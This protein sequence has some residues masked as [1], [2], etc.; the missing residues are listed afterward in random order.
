MFGFALAGSLQSQEPTAAD[1]KPTAEEAVKL[2]TFLVTGSNI[3]RVDAETSLPVTVIDREDLDQRGVSTPA[4]LFDTI[5]MAN[6]PLL[7]EQESA[8]QS[9]RGD[10]AVVDIRGIG[11]GSTLPLVNGRRAAPHPI[12]QSENGTPAL[13]VNI[14]SLPQG[15]ATRVEILRDGASAIYGSDAAAGVVNYLLVPDFD[16]LRTSLRASQTLDGGGNELRASIRWG[17]DRLNGGKTRVM[18]G[19]DFFNRSALTPNDRWWS[20]Q[21]DQRL[22]RQLPAPWDGLPVN[23]INV[24]TGA[25]VIVRDNDFDNSSSNSAFGS[26]V[27]GTVAAGGT[28]TGSRPTS[29]RGIVTTQPGA[30]ATTS[31]NGAFFLTPIDGGGVG[32]R[33]TTPSRNF[34]GVERG[35]YNNLNSGSVIL[36][37]TDRTNLAAAIDHRINDRLTAFGEAFLYLAE[38]TTGRVGPQIDQADAPGIHVGVDNPYNLFGSRFYHATGAPNADGS[39]RLVGSPSPVVINLLRPDDFKNRTIEVESSSYRVVAGLR[40]VFGRGWNWESAVLY[41]S[42]RTYDVERNNIRESKLRRALVSSDPA[43]AFNPFGY[44]FK[45]DPATSLI[46]VDKPFSNSAAVMAGL[47]GSYE[48][49]AWTYLGI[50]DLR[51]DGDLGQL[52]GN[53]IK[54]AGGLEAR[55]E[56]YKFRIPP[57]AGLVPTDDTD[58]FIRQG[59]NDFILLSPN[60]DA[61]LNRTVYSAFAE[62]LV[63]LVTPKNNLSLV[64]AL[65]LSFAT[66]IER[67]P[68]FGDAIKPKVS[69]GYNPTKWLKIRASANE[70]FKAPNL[71]QV[72]I[73]RRQVFASAISDPYRFEVTGA[74][75]DGSTGRTVFREGSGDLVPEEAIN[76]SV[77][78][79]LDVPGVKGLSFT[80][81]AY[82]VNQN[83]TIANATGNFQ[84]RRDEELLDI[85]TQR[86][87]ASGTS[88]N[89]IDLGSGTAT[90]KGNPAINRAPVS[91]ADRDAYATFNAG[92]PA[93]EQRAPVGPVINLVED[94]INLE[95]RD[96]DGIDFGVEYRTPR[97]RDLGQF[98][99]R[100]EG[101]WRHRFEDQTAPDVPIND[102]LEEDGIPIW[103]ANADLR[104]RK[105]SWSLGWFTSYYGSFVD[106]GAATTEAVYVAL[107]S[108][109]YIRPFNNSG[110]V[111]FLYHVKPY[112]AH[113]FNASYRFPKNTKYAYLK[114]TS[115]RFGVNNVLNTPPPISDSTLGYE[116]GAANPRGQQFWLEVAKSW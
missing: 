60:V 71:V 76:Y 45:I 35:F 40:G 44:T 10:N 91:Q 85:E 18:V 36:P 82:K 113:N 21:A 6:P 116:S 63:P 55:N 38:S 61:D 46:Q 31:T 106:T 8:G 51:V 73:P 67:F 94:F 107:G 92:R 47:D 102:N 111:R 108:P 70:S 98:T 65:D 109:S 100:L 26:Y 50:W 30:N 101:S 80:V 3:R 34:D 24:T 66:R 20:R 19:V 58:P 88:A 89:N 56:G 93:A 37:K 2:D 81:D 52:W 96:L 115:V 86:L 23:T 41:G 16:G 25:T 114:G 62:V 104:W 79:V 105:D 11:S 1:R 78:F 32:F 90:Y 7:T 69:L 110:S 74:L 112:I 14:N 97:Y 84:L 77:G 27:R 28:I 103:R 75:G 42:A 15:L 9:A 95:G 29:N 5:T 68:N 53:D 48:R 4:E 87:I 72:G 13:S 12:S 49:E 17:D 39:T 64:R 22:I 99:F 59:D 83:K 33:Q 57:Y 54:I 43:T